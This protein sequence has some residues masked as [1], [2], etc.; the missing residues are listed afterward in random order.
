MNQRP[1]L[2]VTCNHLYYCPT[3]ILSILYLDSIACS[4]YSVWSQNRKMTRITCST[5][6]H[7]HV[8]PQTTITTSNANIEQANSSHAEKLKWNE[9]CAPHT[10]KSFICISCAKRLFDVKQTINLKLMQR[11]EEKI[12]QQRQQ[13]QQSD[14]NEWRLPSAMYFVAIEV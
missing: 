13:H 2:A 10:Q 5:W 6:S 9:Q 4:Y 3:C 11:A 1:A 7:S 14:V 12:C 8:A